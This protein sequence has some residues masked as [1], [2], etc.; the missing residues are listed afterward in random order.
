ML[1]NGF[2][3]FGISTSTDFV[4]ALNVI[5]FCNYYGTPLS[6]KAVIGLQIGPITVFYL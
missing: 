6:P 4:N 2:I 5:M 1:N 3:P